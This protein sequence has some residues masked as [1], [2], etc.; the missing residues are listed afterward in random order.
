MFPFIGQKRQSALRKIQ[1]RRKSHRDTANRFVYHVLV[2][3]AAESIVLF[4]RQTLKA[5]LRSAPVGAPSVEVQWVRQSRSIECPGAP[6]GDTS[7][8]T[9]A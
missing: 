4:G 3:I 7:G 8:P 5:V 1:A 9:V 2:T 6:V